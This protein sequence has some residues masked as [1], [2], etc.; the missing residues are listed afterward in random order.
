MSDEVHWTR[1]EAAGFRAY[2]KT[3]S[4]GILKQLDQSSPTPLTREELL[5]MPS[6]AIARQQLLIEGYRLAITVLHSLAEDPAQA[7]DDSN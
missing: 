7:P 6:E 2:L 4:G 5:T 1:R 3:S